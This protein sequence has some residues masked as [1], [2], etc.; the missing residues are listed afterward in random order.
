MDVEYRILRA[1][2]DLGFVVEECGGF[3]ARNGVHIER[4]DVVIWHFVVDFDLDGRFSDEFRSFRQKHS[5][6]LFVIAV[7][8]DEDLSLVVFRRDSQ[9]VEESAHAFFVVHAHP[10]V[11]FQSERIEH[12][13]AFGG[14]GFDFEGPAYVA[15]G[16]VSGNRG[17]YRKDKISR[18]ASRFFS[19]ERL[20]EKRV[21]LGVVRIRQEFAR[22]GVL[23]ENF[24]VSREIFLFQ[25]DLFEFRYEIEK[26]VF[27]RIRLGD[28]VFDEHAHQRGEIVRVHGLLD[29]FHPD[30]TVF[31][32]EV[33]N[34]PLVHDRYAVQARTAGFLVERVD[35][36]EIPCHFRVVVRVAEPPFF[37]DSVEPRRSLF[38]IG[39][40]VP[41]V[42]VDILFLVLGE[43]SLV[44]FQEHRR[45]R[46]ASGRAD[47]VTVLVKYQIALWGLVPDGGKD[48]AFPVERES[49]AVLRGDQERDGAFEFLV[50]FGLSEGFDLR[51][52]HEREGDFGV[53]FFHRVEMRVD[54]IRRLEI[55]AGSERGREVRIF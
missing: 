13:A 21:D 5:D 28:L 17:E 49:Q 9:V 26:H 46:K 12:L 14:L 36:G 6:V 35:D 7:A 10:V 53:D 47:F 52:L 30:G 33:G 43:A 34:D 32:Q 15:V 16:L 41:I 55:A 38:G 19:G 24:E 1:V 4:K 37:R 2:P 50:E 18:I 25:E 11:A 20:F 48:G 39:E 3:V 45:T 27:G 31:P 44:E 8:L 42:V 54:E 29:L 40:E 23:V 51:I 22:F